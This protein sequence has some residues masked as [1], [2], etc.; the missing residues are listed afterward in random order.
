MVRRPRGV[1][2]FRPSGSSSSD[3]WAPSF[4]PR[5]LRILM[6]TYG[7]ITPATTSTTKVA[8]RAGVQAGRPL[9]IVKRFRRSR[10][11]AWVVVP[12]VIALCLAVTAPAMAWR[13][14][15]PSGRSALIQ[16]VLRDAGSHKSIHVSQIRVSTVGPWA[17]ATVTFDVA[18]SPG[19]S[20]V[21]LHMVQGEW[22]VASHGTAGEWC[23]MPRKDQRNL[24]FPVGG[25]CG[26]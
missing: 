11:L 21:I 6:V 17:S 3:P 4:V 24:G 20:T 22:I 25:V 12:I 2:L 19:P 18:N 5:T 15:T 1:P 23:V 7:G 9:M 13:H 10:S 8:L 16:A 26:K 14:P